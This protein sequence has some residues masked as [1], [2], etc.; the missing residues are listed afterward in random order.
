MTTARAS[1][2]IGKMWARGVPRVGHVDRLRSI[3]EAPHDDMVGEL[4]DAEAM[5]DFP[6]KYILNIDPRSCEAQLEDTYLASEEDVQFSLLH[7]LGASPRKVI[8][9]V[10]CFGRL[11][12]RLVE[13]KVEGA[14]LEVEQ[15]S[16]RR[17]RSAAR[18]GVRVCR[19]SSARGMFAG[20][21]APQE[22]MASAVVA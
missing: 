12:Q 8:A 19:L 14:D 11:H 7:Q 16:L 20:C 15:A 13:A 18:T 21:A 1:L 22:G 10:S 2:P 6:I 9:M 3:A 4:T 17:L 5:D